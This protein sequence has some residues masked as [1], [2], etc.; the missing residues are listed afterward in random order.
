VA[1]VGHRPHNSCPDNAI[2]LVAQRELGGYVKLG[3]WAD[4]FTQTWQPCHSWSSK[5]AV[6]KDSLCRG[7]SRVPVHT[8]TT[9]K[10]TTTVLVAPKQ[11]NSQ[12]AHST[13]QW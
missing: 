11:V 12:Y 7:E 2:G 3:S 4:I 1:D 5:M 8:V 13:V 6:R 9:N 10:S